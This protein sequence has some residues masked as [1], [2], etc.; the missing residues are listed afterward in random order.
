MKNISALLSTLL[1]I[2][3]TANDQNFLLRT[4]C[5]GKVPYLFHALCDLSPVCSTAPVG[6]SVLLFTGSPENFLCK[7]H[8]QF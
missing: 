7:L 3:S 4:I 6:G 8:S 5:I 2:L 1:D